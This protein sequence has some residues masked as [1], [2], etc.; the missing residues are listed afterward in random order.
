[1][2]FGIFGYLKILPM[3]FKLKIHMVNV[4]LFLKRT[5]VLKYVTVKQLSKSF[6]SFV[7]I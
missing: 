3:I 1:M 6:Q 2:E 5:E 7:S 4:R